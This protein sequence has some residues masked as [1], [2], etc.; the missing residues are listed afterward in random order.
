MVRFTYRRRHSYN[1]RS[2][3]WAVVRTPGNNLNVQ[4]RKKP[5]AASKCG[6]CH[7]PNLFGLGRLRK[8]DASRA[9]K[10]TKTVQRAYGGVQC[11][12]CVRER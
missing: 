10:T 7:L 9:S 2:N 12:E 8:V 4:Y 5:V 11:A 1:T 6:D 3:K